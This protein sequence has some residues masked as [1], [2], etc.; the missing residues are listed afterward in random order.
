[1]GERIFWISAIVILSLF[2][3]GSIAPVLARGGTNVG[4]IARFPSTLSVHVP[5]VSMPSRI[6]TP[7]II[8][9]NTGVQNDLRL[10][11]G[12]QLQN[13]WPIA[14]WPYLSSID[15]TPIVVPPVGSEIPSD[16]PVIVISGSPNG[17]PEPAALEPPRDYSYV[18]GCRAIPNGY[19]CDAPHSEAVPP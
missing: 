10:R 1:M 3:T 6:V 11:R 17:A 8:A 19:H 15:T 14:I 2:G 12:A 18:A 16:Q 7:R 5:R 9:R 4:G 13:G